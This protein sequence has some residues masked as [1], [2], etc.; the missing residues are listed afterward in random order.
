[1]EESSGN[2]AAPSARH[3]SPPLALLA[4]V[5]VG[6]FLASLVVGTAL[7]AG[8]HFPSPFLPGADQYFA[9]HR[10]AVELAAVL[11]FGAAVPLGLFTATVTSRLQFLGIRAAGV[12]IASF[13]GLA[14]SFFMALSALFQ[15][16]LAQP[17]V[18]FPE[19][20]HL[21]HLAAFATGG[22]GHVVPLGLLVAGVSVAGGLSRRLPRWLM[23]A[24]VLVAAVAELS[25]LAL[26]A[27]PA[28]FALPLARFSALA[29]MVV[30][31]VLLPASRASTREHSVAPT[32]VA[33][34]A[35]QASR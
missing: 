11:Q 32:L 30:V 4:S 22:P 34:R 10:G 12:H 27:R 3:Q 18:A 1:M 9:R 13:G 14:A 28:A 7:A 20:T 23:S 31:G 5:F 24:G 15:W 29:W 35:R 33:G 16:I 21:L 17:G 6:L 19:T 25:T 8:A 2:Q 26:L